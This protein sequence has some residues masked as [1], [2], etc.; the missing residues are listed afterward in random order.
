MSK[1]NSIVIAIALLPL[2]SGCPTPVDPMPGEL[3]IGVLDR[4]DG[5]FHV[6]SDGDSMPVLLGANGLNMVVPSVRAVGVNP[7]RPNPDVQVEVAGY[8]MAAI[9]EAER[10]PMDPDAEGNGYVLGNLQTPFDAE[11]CCF[12]CTEGT[13][14]ASLRD[15]SGRV[16]EGQVTVRLE[17]G[18]CPDV[19]ACCMNASDCEDPSLTQL[20]M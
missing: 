13:I 2:L 5:T 9:L 17:R 14:T 10:V 8:V 6:L 1:S 12:V 19:T 11:L 18:G 4:V 3:E 15:A 20:C 16:F 7:N